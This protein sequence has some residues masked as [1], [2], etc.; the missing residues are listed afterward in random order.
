MF[1]KRKPDTFVCYEKKLGKHNFEMQ[2]LNILEIQY[3]IGISQL[4][5]EKKNLNRLSIDLDFSL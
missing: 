3:I 1:I 2:K 4:H 5:G